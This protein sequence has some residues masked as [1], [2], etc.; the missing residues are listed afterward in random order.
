MKSYINIF[1]KNYNPHA[2]TYQQDL[3]LVE[4]TLKTRANFLA[5]LS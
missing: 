4:V 5:I 1:H 2:S 3:L